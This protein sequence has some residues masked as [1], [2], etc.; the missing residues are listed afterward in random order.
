MAEIQRTFIAVKPDGVQRSLIGEIISRLERRGLKLIAI[1]LM[2]VSSAQA[3]EHYGVHKSK[4]FYDGLVK[5]ITSGPIVAMVWEGASAVELARQS[6]GAT[7]PASAIP[8][9]IR[10][11][12]AIDIQHNLVH[13]SDSSE[14]ASKE[15]AIF[16]KPAELLGSWDRTLDRWISG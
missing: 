16:F 3:E 15:I 2:Q 11:D 10:G 8:G 9:S 5:F 6:I 7:N 12:L 4:P 13:G 1:K 14:N